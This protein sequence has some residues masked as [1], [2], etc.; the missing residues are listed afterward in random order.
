[1]NLAVQIETFDHE[2]GSH[3][4]HRQHPSRSGI[5]KLLELFSGVELRRLAC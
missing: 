3:K 5:I 4:R 2:T 1:M